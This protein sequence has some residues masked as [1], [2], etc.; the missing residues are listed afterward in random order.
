MNLESNH[1]KEI[2]DVTRTAGRNDA[3]DALLAALAEKWL[4]V[5]GSQ[6]KDGSSVIIM[7]SREATELCESCAG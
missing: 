4:E 2:P 7:Q 3:K 5:S 1:L 6:E